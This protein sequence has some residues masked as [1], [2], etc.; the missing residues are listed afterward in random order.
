[1]RALLP[2]LAAIACCAGPALAQSPAEQAL[3]AAATPGERATLLAEI[4]ADDPNSF[5]HVLQGELR[6]RGFR[7]AA[8]NGQFTIATIRELNA[9]CAEAGIA[10]ICALGPLTPTG[11]AALA[12]ALYAS[13]PAVAEPAPPP[14]AP[15]PEPPAD[16]DDGSEPG[17]AFGPVA[18]EADRSVWT[19]NG[20]E[21][22]G[23][24]AIATSPVDLRRTGIYDPVALQWLLGP[25]NYAPEAD[26]TY[27]LDFT[28]PVAGGPVRLYPL[29]GR[30]N[31]R[32]LYTVVEGLEA[33]ADYTVHWHVA[34]DGDAYTVTDLTVVAR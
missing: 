33:G 26:G 18:V 7:S 29:R 2:I 9:F 1:M 11:V 5:V 4:F 17:F 13:M 21:L 31:R 32:W 22:A 25:A 14:P 23:S 16:D 10:K 28:T 3:A 19:W 20:M 12:E 30:D 6:Q 34:I 27:S 15:R 24:P 8:P